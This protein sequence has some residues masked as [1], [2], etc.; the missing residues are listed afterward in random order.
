MLLEEMLHQIRLTSIF[1]MPAVKHPSIPIVII[2]NLPINAGSQLHPLQSE[3]MHQG[4]PVVSIALVDLYVIL[5][6]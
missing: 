4:E 3:S 2:C 5:M 1:N 6:R